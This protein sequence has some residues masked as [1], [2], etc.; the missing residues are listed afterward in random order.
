MFETCVDLADILLGFLLAGIIMYLFYLW[1][2]AGSE[3]WGEWDKMTSMTVSQKN[4][5]DRKLRYFITPNK[6]LA[7]TYPLFYF[8]VKYYQAYYGF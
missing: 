8:W 6:W 4:E 5:K 2:K 1:V 3:Q 7:D